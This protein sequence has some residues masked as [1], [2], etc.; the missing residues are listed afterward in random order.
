LICSLKK[1]MNLLYDQQLIDDGLYTPEIG[2]WGIQKYKLVY[3]YCQLF[4]TSMKKKWDYRVYI[5]LFSG[6]G[7]AR[8]KNTSRVVHTSPLLAINIPDKFDTYIFCEENKEALDALQQRVSSFGIRPPPEFIY[9]DANHSVDKI[10]E[11]MPSYSRSCKVLAFCFVDPFKLKNLHFST[12]IKLSQKF[13]DFLVLIPTHMDAKR[14]VSYYISPQNKTIDN[15]TG[16]SKWREDWENKKDEQNFDIFLTNS[17][18]ESMA[19]LGYLYSGV[20]DTQLI[21]SSEKNLALY[22]LVFFSRNKLGKK[23]WKDIK[24]ICDPQKKLF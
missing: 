15:F 11:K 9:G 1:H 4:A 7:C 18:G 24:K 20:Q 22:R 10:F 21:R 2:S 8:I 14:N 16:N 17:F 13:M 3:G 6:A 5:D 12:I 19:Q 23:F